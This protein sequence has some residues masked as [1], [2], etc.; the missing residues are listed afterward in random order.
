MRKAILAVLVALILLPAFAMAAGSCTQ[1]T[2]NYPDTKTR[3]VFFVCTGDAENGSIPNTATST[4]ITSFIK[5]HRLLQVET[6]PTSGGTAPDAADV[7]VLDAK[8]M[9]LLGSEDGNTTAYQGLNLIHATLKRTAFPD[10]YTPR[11]GLH[12]FYYPYVTGALTLKVA[13]QATVSAN[14]TV[15]LTFGK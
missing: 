13:N 6:Y 9:D 2:E 10:A 7:F 15:V 4:P 3:K 12:A 5:E 11:A 1:S 14:Y 8:S